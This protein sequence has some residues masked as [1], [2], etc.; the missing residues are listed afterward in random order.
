V[1]HY[2]SWSTAWRALG[3]PQADRAEHDMT[4][5]QLRLHVHA[6]QRE[7]N[8][9]P[10]YVGNLLAETITEAERYRHTASVLDAEAHAAGDDTTRA[11]RHQEAA[12][13]RAVAELRE[14][15]IAQ[16]REGE[17]AYTQ[18]WLHTTHTRGKAERAKAA[19]AARNATASPD[20]PAV[21]GQEWLTAEQETRAAE[22]TYREITD[23]ADFA[24]VH[25][26]HAAAPEDTVDTAELETNVADVR[27]T[28]ASTVDE[29]SVRVPTAAEITDVVEGAQR[30][31]VEMQHRATVEEQR[32][33]D[34]SRAAQLARWQADD[35]A[36]EVDQAAQ[37][38]STVDSPALGDPE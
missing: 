21:T 4:D 13:Y 32:E 30:A 8:W 7:Q 35:R 37:R 26:E 20:E 28:P 25:Q 6:W 23:E 12:D 33:A 36:V 24:D 16:L 17:H 15:H 5:A 9:A 10:A 38:E 3:R 1:E 18:W 34:Q 27:D 11:G 19:L 2:A 22:D 29:D 14:R 31:I